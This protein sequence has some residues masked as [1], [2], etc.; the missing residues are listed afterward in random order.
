[1]VV[2]LL[3]YLILMVVCLLSLFNIELNRGIQCIYSSGVSV[4][5]LVAH[6][7]CKNV[8]VAHTKVQK[9]NYYKSRHFVKLLLTF[10]RIYTF[11]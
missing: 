6:Q 9:K 2:C 10:L 7:R 5:F 3:F 8:L 4:L 11:V 1:M